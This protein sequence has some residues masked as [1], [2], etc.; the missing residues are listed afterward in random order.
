MSKLSN[1]FP[2][3]KRAKKNNLTFEY[4]SIGIL[5]LLFI[6]IVIG[7]IILRSSFKQT[8]AIFVFAGA[9][10]SLYA[11]VFQLHKAIQDSKVVVQVKLT[12]KVTGDDALITCSITNA[13]TKTLY[14]FLTNLYISE[15]IPETDNNVIRYK[16]EPIT[17]HSFY[18]RNN[19]ECF[20]CIVSRHCKKEAQKFNAKD[21]NPPVTFP[22][23][24]HDEFR[25]TL[26]YCCN[27][28]LLS[29]VS[30]LHIMPKETFKE[31]TVISIKKPGYYRA[32]VIYLD[33]DWDDCTCSSTTFKIG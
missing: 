14:P 4:V 26:R 12:A 1:K 20:D 23:C 10:L 9:L 18:R 25:N 6:T 27:L 7:A 15:S 29:Y 30:L 13:G 3:H 2:I 33:K 21:N 28:K 11:L 22:E 24:S 8:D 17:Q 32:F 31:D 5:I 19:E 16:F